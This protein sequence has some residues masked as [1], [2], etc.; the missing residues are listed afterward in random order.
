MD[1]LVSRPRFY[2]V[3]RRRS[4]VDIQN[5]PLQNHCPEVGR[6]VYEVIRDRR[7]E[8]AKRRRRQTGESIASVT[9]SCGFTDKTHLKKLFLRRVGCSMREWR[10]SGR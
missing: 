5:R 7:L 6:S 1:R 8:E 10:R 4:S 2:A 9:A 3:S